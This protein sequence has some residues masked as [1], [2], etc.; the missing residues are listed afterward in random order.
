MVETLERVATGIVMASA[1]V[2]YEMLR[3]A[4]LFEVIP[5]YLAG[6][7]APLWGMQSFAAVGEIAPEIHLGPGMSKV[8]AKQLA[9]FVQHQAFLEMGELDRAVI[10]DGWEIWHL[11][12]KIST[13]EEYRCVTAELV[14]N[15]VITIHAASTLRGV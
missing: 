3:L 2:N 7:D 1:E 6:D 9:L 13:G 8:F 11:F 12:P 4:E 5:Q 14:G 10:E 15:S